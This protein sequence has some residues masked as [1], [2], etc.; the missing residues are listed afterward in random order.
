MLCTFN[1]LY[2]LFFFHQVLNSGKL[3][4]DYLGKVLEFALI[5]L[6]KLSAPAT[7]DELKV[8][9]LS[10][11]KELA[12]ICQAGNDLDHLHSIGLINLCIFSQFISDTK[13]ELQ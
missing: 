2:V 13:C 1:T 7:E 5:T 9:H 12:E 3:D 11:L 6:Q 8:A 4:M 10:M